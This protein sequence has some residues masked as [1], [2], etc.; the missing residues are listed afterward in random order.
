M[1]DSTRQR[2]PAGAYVFEIFTASLAGIL[3]EISYTRIFSFKVYYYFTYLILG[4]GLLGIGSA[5]VAVATSQRLRRVPAERLLAIACTAGG[6]A[7]LAGYFVIAPMQL[8]VGEVFRRPREALE[9]LLVSGVLALPFF[10]VGLVISTILSASPERASRLYAADLVGAALACTASIP[11]MLA[12]DPP[13][14]VILS[15]LLLALAGARLALAARA[16]ALASAAVL[17]ALAV[18]LAAPSLLRDPVVA[19]QKSYEDYR[20]AGLV[21]HTRWSPVFRVDVSEAPFQQGETWVL[22]HD[23]QMGSSM[24]RFDGDLGKWDSFRTDVRSQPFAILPEGPRVLVI[25]AAGG[26]EILASL[27]F[28][29]SHVT[30]IELNP[31]TY[32]VVTQVF[33]EE[34]GHLAEHPR[35]TLLNGDGRWFL[36]Q[37]EEKYDL[38]WFVAPDS[39][40]AMNASTSGAFVLSESYLYTVETVRESLRH[41]TQR[42]VICAQFGE[43]DFA[44][45]PNRSV[46]YVATARAALEAEGVADAS[47]QLLVSASLGF[48]PFDEVSIVV[49]RSPFGEREIAAFEKQT[50]LLKQGTVYWR[51]GLAAGGHPVAS[52]AALPAEALGRWHAGLQYQNDAVY[53][54]SPFFWHFVSFRDALTAQLPIGD[55]IFDYED[56]VGEQVTLVFLGILLVLAAVLLLL[57]LWTLRGVF[58]QLPRKA[59]SGVYFASLGLGFM[60]V[61]VALIQRLT[62]L[63][64]YPTYSLT[65]SLF[66]ILVFSGLG[67]LLCGRW[68][69]HGMPA[70]VVSFL[71]LA[72]ALAFHVLAVPPIVKVAVGAPLPARILLAVALIAPLGLCLGVFMPT[73]LA[74]VGR[75]SPHA[76][77]YVAWAWAVNGFF[78]VIASVLATTLAMAYGF[79]VLLLL[80]LAIYALGILAASRML[81]AAPGAR[82]A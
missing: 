74:A 51:P 2:P 76:R 43:F 52:A 56:A 81:A 63:L 35:V 53:D 49:G 42:G 65:V 58:G 36:S 66:G 40:A 30:A 71:V 75:L 45:K 48:A 3:L 14:T 26:H 60:F 78:S 73:G 82:P 1:D 59:A 13:R 9:I 44:G 72:A 67:S 80:S 22:H 8:E 4:L 37:S 28:G 27:Y 38:I 12:I 34:T 20:N 25:G 70:L 18:P 46:R 61:E 50:A 62:L 41:L 10:C 7:V 15:G 6:A 29:A 33:A 5:G 68:S 31:A 57:P 55:F 17:A 24:R 19:K 64:G 21:R 32:E 39:Y 79:R 77:E 69:R 47:R 11:V 23:G 54:D 16:T